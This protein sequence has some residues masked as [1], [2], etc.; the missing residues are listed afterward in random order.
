ME[1]KE[2]FCPI[3]P[4]GRVYY[5]TLCK[6]NCALYDHRAEQCAILSA[7][8]AIKNR[9]EKGNDESWAKYT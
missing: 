7:C 3:Y 2:I 6:P 5:S 1:G 8:L 4:E 9:E